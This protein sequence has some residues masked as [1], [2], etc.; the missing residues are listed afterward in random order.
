MAQKTKAEILAE[1]NSLLADN[2]A[3]NISAEDVR[4]VF[5]DI[6]DSFVNLSDAGITEVE[7]AYLAGVTSAIQTQLNNKANLNGA[8]FTGGVTIENNVPQ[9]I[10]KDANGSIDN[11]DIS[12][13]LDDGEFILQYLRDN[14]SGGGKYI[15]MPRFDNNLLSMD[16]MNPSGIQAKIE[17]SGDADFR[18]NLTANTISVDNGATFTG[19]IF[20]SGSI[21]LLQ[22]IDTNAAVDNQ[23][24]NLR[25]ESGN[26]R[27]QFLTD[28]GSGGGDYMQ[29][30]RSGANM[31]ALKLF[32]DAVARITLNNEG[33]ATFNQSVTIG[34]YTLSATD[35]TAGQVLTTDGAGNVSFE[36]KGYKEALLYVTQTGTDAPIIT[37]TIKN[38]FTNF[39]F[40]YVSAGRYSFNSDEDLTT[41]VFAQFSNSKNLSGTLIQTLLPN[42]GTIVSRSSDSS[43]G[44]LTNAND[45]LEGYLYLRK[46]N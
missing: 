4:T 22:F 26:L 43:I 30:E 27:F 16:F 8:D 36:G 13:T 15:Q 25:G 37:T 46:Y 44:N 19:T 2:T 9:L 14:G 42:N 17:T 32:D 11:K 38:D 20:L 29:I 18:G 5:T 39:L 3:G 21:P 33:T 23:R 31:T 1:I 35:G 6:K 34:D 41:S 12:L 7:A 24:L 28:A 40:S 45:V 10:L